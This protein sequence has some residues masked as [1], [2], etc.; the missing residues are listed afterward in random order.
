MEEILEYELLDIEWELNYEFDQKS[1]CS[2]IHDGTKE[3]EKE[4]V[5]NPS[6]IYDENCIPMGESTEAIKIRRQM[7]YDFYE[8]WKVLHPDKSIYNKSLKSNILIRQESVIEAAAHAAKRYKSTLAVYKLD[9]VLA[10]ATKVSEDIPK[11]GNKNQ[12]KL[13]RM[14]LMS[15]DHPVIGRIKLTVGVRNRTLDKIQYGITA[16][17]EN[18][19]IAPATESKKKALHKK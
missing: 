14:I 8:Q 12:R 19:T 17:S 6:L 11:P 15:Y 10:K 1:S 16:I 3:S 18:E 2:M 7:I 4:D 9:E 13:I 5:N